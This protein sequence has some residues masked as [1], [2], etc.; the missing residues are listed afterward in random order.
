[1]AIRL[2]EVLL[3]LGRAAGGLSVP[4]VSEQIIQSITERNLHREYIVYLRDQLNN[5]LDRT[6]EY[7]DGETENHR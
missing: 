1:M 5:I 4:D 6:K 3:A 7:T 2:D